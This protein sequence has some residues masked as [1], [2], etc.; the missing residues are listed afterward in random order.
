MPAAGRRLEGK[1]ALISGGARG[2][3]ASIATLFVR[4]GASVMLGDIRDELGAATAEEISAAEGGRCVYQHLDVTSSEDWAAAVARC[5]QELGPV[6]VLVS[7]AF[8]WVMGNVAD[9]SPVAWQET[10]DVI[11]SGAFHGI[12][13]VLPSMRERGRG[14]IIAI[15]SSVGGEMAAPDFA[16]Y[17][18]AKAGLT[19]LIKHVGGTFASEG[20]RANSIHPGPIRTPALVDNGFT[21]GA[22]FAASGFPIPRISEPE[23]IA[24]AA[25]YLASDESSYMTASKMVIDGGS[26]SFLGDVHQHGAG[27]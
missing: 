13:A 25:V 8:K 10:L 5:E 16:P 22:E 3:G 6:D 12:R 27:A 9:V 18:A 19:A 15:S 20:V 2:L 23:E 24:W 11:L 7:N 4:E 17:Q 26:S 14:S 1:V 21:E